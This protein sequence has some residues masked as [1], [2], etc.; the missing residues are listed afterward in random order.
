MLL[1]P[2]RTFVVKISSDADATHVV[3]R[4]E[5]VT[6][7]STARFEAIEEL[8]SFLAKILGQEQGQAAPQQKDV[9]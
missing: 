8:G 6:S 7:G 3:G 9:E 4:V 2:R 5:H 1:S